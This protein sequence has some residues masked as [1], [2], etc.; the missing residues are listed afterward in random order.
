MLLADDLGQG[1]G[2]QPVGERRVLRPLQ[3]LR[4]RLLIGEQIGNRRTS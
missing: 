4:R 2:P 3:P 1:G